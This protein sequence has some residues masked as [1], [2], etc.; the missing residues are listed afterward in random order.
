MVTCPYPKLLPES[1]GA[2]SA[3]GFF[4]QK[5]KDCCKKHPQCRLQQSVTQF[6]PT[7]LVEVGELGDAYVRLRELRTY[8]AE[9]PYFCLS[10]CWGEKQP[11]KLTKETYSILQEGIS[12]ESLPKTFRDAI[13]VT[14]NFQVRYLWYVL[15]RE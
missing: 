9:G 8:S 1:T 11:F 5:Y 12:L 2:S 6:Y 7:R 13:L 3:I 14:R 15:C 10:H 4:L